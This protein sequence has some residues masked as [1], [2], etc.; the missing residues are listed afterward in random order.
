MRRKSSTLIPFEKEIL[1]AAEELILQGIKTFHGF[2]IAK[3]LKDRRSVQALIKSGVLYR[4][5]DRLEKMGLL[6]SQWEDPTL[7]AYNNHPRRRLYARTLKP[8]ADFADTEK[9][10][11]E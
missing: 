8:V 6:A 10:K 3:L 2:Q 11:N 5:L 9:D 4:A 7:A 1:R